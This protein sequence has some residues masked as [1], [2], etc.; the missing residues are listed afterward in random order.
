MPS[1]KHSVCISCMALKA[2]E[3]REGGA[4]SERHYKKVIQRQGKQRGKG[5]GD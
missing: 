2:G 5:D 4:M 3:A 1:L